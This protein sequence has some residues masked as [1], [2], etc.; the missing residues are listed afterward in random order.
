MF[1]SRIATRTASAFAA[2]LLLAGPALPARAAD[3]LERVARSGELV[4]SGYGDLP[5]LL[6]V[7]PGRQP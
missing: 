1:R 7:Q 5:P 2:G 6:S 3:V 4:L